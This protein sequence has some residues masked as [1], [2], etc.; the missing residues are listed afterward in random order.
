MYKKNLLLGILFFTTSI[1]FSQTLISMSPNTANI[2]Q[3]L[4]TTVTA[5]GF[6]FTMASMPGPYD[7]YLLQGN[8]QITPNWV[9]MIDDDNLDVNITIPAAA[10]TGSYQLVHVVY[11]FVPPFNANYYYLG[12]AF[13]VYDSCNIVVTPLGAQVCTGDSVQLSF[14]SSASTYQWKLNGV[15]IPGANQ[16]NYYAKTS[17]NYTL[18]VT[19]NTCTGSITPVAVTILPPPTAAITPSAN[20]NLCPGQSVTLQANTGAG[21]TYQWNKNGAVIPGATQISLLVKDS[22][23]YQVTV[24]NSSGCKNI[25]TPVKVSFSQLPSILLTKQPGASGGKDAKLESY[26]PNSNYGNDVQL[27]AVAWTINGNPVYTRSVFQFDLSSVPPGSVILSAELNLYYDSTTTNVYH[28][29]GQ[30]TGYLQRVTAP[31]SES[32]VNWNNQPP[33]TSVNQAV[34]PTSTSSYQDYLHIDVRDLVRTMVDSPAV[35]YGFLLKIAAESPYKTLLFC[36]S[37]YPNQARRPRLVIKY[38][39]VNVTASNGL[40]FCNGDSSILQANSGNYSYQWKKNGNAINGATASAYTAK[41]SGTYLVKITNNNGCSVLSPPKVITVNYNP[42]ATISSDG[43]TTFCA[44]DSVVLAGN[45]GTNLSYQ[46]KKNNG[47]I[48]G[49]TARKYTAKTAGS[50]KVKVTNVYGCTRL[51]SA[52]TVTVPCR[53]SEMAGGGSLFTVDAYPNP[54]GGDFHFRLTNGSDENVRIRIYDLTGRMVSDQSYI[55]QHEIVVSNIAVPG[56][57]KAEV[58]QGENIKVISL[59]KTE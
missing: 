46:W 19:G 54:S 13:T 29:Y 9:N 53:E 14:T 30:N 35:N 24:T 41:T 10:P 34:L 7:T 55:M 11:T 22:G 23:N 21:L 5:S 45:S 20:Q 32:T 18:A 57:Y 44:G 36:T 16:Q 2:N 51:S 49:A 59:I 43:P 58:I 25:S 52:V 47:T 12:N 56:L 38:A 17:G 3:T 31:W 26:S 8:Y 50:Y 4:N 6:F 33:A 15:N 37:D 42:A 48:N 40:T 39:G 28:Q 27:Y 1:A